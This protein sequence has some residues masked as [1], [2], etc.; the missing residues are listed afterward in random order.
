MAKPDPDQQRR[1]LR[2][3]RPDHPQRWG[4]VR[5]HRY[6]DQQ[7]TGLVEV[8]MGITLREI[9]YDIGGGIVDGRPFKAVQ[10]GGPSGGCIPAQSWTCRS[11]TSR[12]CSS[13]AA[14]VLNS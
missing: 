2:Q 3:H 1:D 12:R 9:V 7:N 11:T 5:R 8:P 6:R 10:T 4:L 14:L 13:V